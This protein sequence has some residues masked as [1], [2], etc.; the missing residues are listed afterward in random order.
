MKDSSDDDDLN[1]GSP[2]Q[3]AFEQSNIKTAGLETN[4]VII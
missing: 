2:T 1:Y 3:R 4:L